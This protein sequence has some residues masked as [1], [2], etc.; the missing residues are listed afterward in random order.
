VRDGVQG[1]QDQ[2]GEQAPDL[3]DGQAGQ[4][5]RVLVAGGAPFS[6]SVARTMVRNAVAAMDKVMWAY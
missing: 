3:V 5:A 2:G 4:A 1:G 6:A